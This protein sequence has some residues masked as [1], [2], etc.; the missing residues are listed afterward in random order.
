[1]IVT[2]EGSYQCSGLSTAVFSGDSPFRP[3][4]FLNE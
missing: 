4:A 3:M 1:M 2:S